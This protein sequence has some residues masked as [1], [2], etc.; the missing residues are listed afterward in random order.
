MLKDMATSS[1]TTKEIIKN[2]KNNALSLRHFEPEGI[3]TMSRFLSVHPGN[4]HL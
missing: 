1:G 2:K 4:D 3:Q